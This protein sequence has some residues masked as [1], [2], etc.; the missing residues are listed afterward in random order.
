MAN[1]KRKIDYAAREAH[2]KNVE[3]AKQQEQAAKR[4]AFLEK[5]KKQL[6][7]G[8]PAV[9]VVIVAVWLICKATIGPGGSIPNF[10]GNLQGDKR[11]AVL[12][13]GRV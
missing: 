7:I 1:R 4:K 5:Y 3:R 6:I 13:D 12:Q 9:I 11:A 8:I 10:F 2:R